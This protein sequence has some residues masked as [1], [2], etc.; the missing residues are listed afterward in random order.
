MKVM[1]LYHLKNVLVG[2]A[3]VQ[4]VSG[5]EKKRVSIAETLGSAGSLCVWD[6]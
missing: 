6:K 2:N 1:G 4:G 3:E 5:G